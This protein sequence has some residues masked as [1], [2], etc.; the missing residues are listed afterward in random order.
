MS[1]NPRETT[2]AVIIAAVATAIATGYMQIP[3]AVLQSSITQAFLLVMAL[4]LFAYSPVVGI[5]AFAL[6]AILLFNRNVQKAMRYSQAARSVY[7][8]DNI[9]REPVK[10]T[11]GY[12]TMT[13]EPREYNKFKDTYEAYES[14]DMDGLYPLD[15]STDAQPKTTSYMY[16][17]AED[18]G[19]N[20][21]IRD[22]P[23]MD[24]KGASFAY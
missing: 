4:V 20:S 6:F 23:E 5:A 10:E 19:D 24:M 1:N 11:T 22:G 17:P 18:M 2:L 15:A 14:P 9:A 16:R 8:A 13:D 7:G 21:F 12:T 3:A